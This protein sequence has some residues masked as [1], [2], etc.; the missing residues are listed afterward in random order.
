MGEYWRRLGAAGIATFAALSSPEDGNHHFLGPLYDGTPKEVWQACSALYAPVSAS[1]ELWDRAFEP[2]QAFEANVW[3]FNDTHQA[4]EVSWQTVVADENGTAVRSAVN[5]HLVP[6]HERLIVP[7]RFELPQHGSRAVVQ[8]AVL[9]APQPVS[10][11]PVRLHRVKRPNMLIGKTFSMLG[12]EP[13]LRAFALENGMLETN[14]NADLLLG[15]QNALARM[16]ADECF[17]ADVQQ[18]MAQGSG[19]LLAQIG[20]QLWG[21]GYLDDRTQI[22]LDG[23]T[24]LRHEQSWQYRLPFGLT[25]RFDAQAEA[26]SCC[27]PAGGK[28]QF[29]GMNRGA[30]QLSNGYRGNINAP[31]VSM[32]IEPSDR[33]SLLEQWMRRGAPEQMLL[34]CPD[35]TAYHLE[36]FYAFSEAPS[37]KTAIALR[38]RVRFLVADAPS[39]QKRI[40]PEA[41]ME[42]IQLGRLLAE[43]ADSQVAP[44][45]EPLAVCGRDLK[46][47]V[48]CALKPAPDSGTLVL[49]Q[50]LTGGRLAK[51]FEQPG[52]YGAR[53]DPKM[54]Q[55][56]LSL[57]CRALGR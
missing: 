11:W 18:R 50:L 49:S 27:H 2:G 38:Q 24:G 42:I 34:S 16:H 52:L 5:R 12:D 21:E 19:L 35:C 32:E 31:A 28:W 20:P 13:E 46:R 15:G 51:G 30:L 29:D 39:L 41:E 8:A 48:A 10:S 44:K 1:L 55:L 7:A 9:N 25:L 26:E 45:P 40:D 54:I 57:F 53:R 4:V 14:E 33:Q 36:G 17:L 47:V 43:T 23:T 6:A 37:E 3:L 22:R 56:M